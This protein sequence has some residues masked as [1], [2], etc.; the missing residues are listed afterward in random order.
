MQIN[1]ATRNVAF[2]I[3]S[4]MLFE[5][6]L[7]LAP[8]RGRLKVFNISHAFILLT[9]RLVCL[10]EEYRSRIDVVECHEFAASP[11]L[12]SLMLFFLLE[13][14]YRYS[15]PFFLRCFIMFEKFDLA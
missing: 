5:S 1:S 15:L 8:T 10:P 2:N 6:Q 14:R 7:N 4:L 9:V 11:S 3:Q 12:I 13:K